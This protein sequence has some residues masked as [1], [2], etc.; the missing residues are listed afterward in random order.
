MKLLFVAVNQ[1]KVLTLPDVYA[2]IPREYLQD[3]TIYHIKNVN[4]DTVLRNLAVITNTFVEGGLELWLEREKASTPAPPSVNNRAWGI[5]NKV[6]WSGFGLNVVPAGQSQDS[7]SGKTMQECA[8]ICSNDNNRCAGFTWRA[9]E[10]NKNIGSCWFKSDVSS[11]AIPSSRTFYTLTNPNFRNPAPDVQTTVQNAVQA[12][13]AAVSISQ[14]LS[15]ISAALGSTNLMTLMYATNQNRGKVVRRVFELKSAVNFAVKNLSSKSTGTWKGSQV[16]PYIPL[17]AFPAYPASMANIAVDKGKAFVTKWEASGSK[18]ETVTGFTVQFRSTDHGYLYEIAVSSSQIPA[19]AYSVAAPASTP[20]PAAAPPPP[21]PPPTPPTSSA[22]VVPPV[23]RNPATTSTSLPSYAYIASLW[24]PD[25]LHLALAEE[26]KRAQANQWNENMIIGLN[27]P[28]GML[29]AVKRRMTVVNTLLYFL[30]KD[31][32]TKDIEVMAVQRGY[33]N[34]ALLSVL[35][36]WGDL[37]HTWKSGDVPSAVAMENELNKKWLDAMRIPM[38]DGVVGVSTIQQSYNYRA[39][40]VASTQQNTAR[41]KTFLA[42]TNADYSL[43][44]GTRAMALALG[45][46]VVALPSSSY[47]T[48]ATTPSP[49]TTATS[50]TVVTT[51]STPSTGTTASTST[52]P[53]LT[54]SEAGGAVAGLWNQGDVDGALRRFYHYAFNASP[55]FGQVDLANE[56]IKFTPISRWAKAVKTKPSTLDKKYMEA[57]FN[58]SVAIPELKKIFWARPIDLPSAM[59]LLDVAMNK[60][61]TVS[62]GEANNAVDLAFRR[63]QITL[64]LSKPANSSM[65]ADMRKMALDTQTFTT[66]VLTEWMNSDRDNVSYNGQIRTSKPSQT[67]GVSNNV[68]WSGYGL[69]VVPAGSSSDSLTS[70]SLSACAEACAKDNAKCAGFTWRP[71]NKSDPMKGNCW[72]KSD[73]TSKPI[74]SSRLFFTFTNPDFGKPN[75]PDAPINT[76]TGTTTQ[77]TVTGTQST[78]TNTDTG[79]GT[80]STNT[81]ATTVT[82][83]NTDTGT[84]TQSTNTNTTTGTSTSTGTG[85]QSTNTNTNAGT[86]TNTNT[87]TSTQSTNTN[88]GTSTQSTNTNTGTSTQSANEQPLLQNPLTWDPHADPVSDLSSDAVVAQKKQEDSINAGGMPAFVMIPKSLLATKDGKPFMNDAKFDCLGFPIMQKSFDDKWKTEDYTFAS[89]QLA[90]IKECHKNSDEVKKLISDTNGDKTKIANK[91]NSMKPVESEAT[92]QRLVDLGLLP[93]ADFKKYATDTSEEDNTSMIIGISVIAAM[94]IILVI[95]V[96]R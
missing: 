45:Y 96:A 6:T 59:E 24:S 21:P 18:G 31:L 56:V 81:N 53:E 79:T 23:A 50:T 82:S 80:Q 94:F 68:T 70:V 12:A 76:N 62:A 46:S 29:H 38:Q 69:N 47:T 89:A 15:G 20:A 55:A 49:L 19:D 93:S 84:G 9:N 60:A 90:A 10:Q 75:E 11:K 57:A 72:F 1:L 65:H 39:N 95:A 5:E 14:A 26:I 52:G 32:P 88:T 91:L 4:D 7:V 2:I 71:T 36:G 25:Q 8:A 28:S 35:M 92:A 33:I 61:G 78:N 54:L 42:N 37:V 77:S 73:V 87:G 86:T 66:D 74:P 30:T 40:D 22:P 17:S 51:A 13:S 83:T 3:Q 41:I 27:S 44:A 16:L 67:W 34:P 85:T 58:S 48:A 64:F 63:D 43:R